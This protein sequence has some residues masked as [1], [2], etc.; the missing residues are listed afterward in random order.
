[1]LAYGANFEIRSSF[2]FRSALCETSYF[3]RV[4]GI[5]RTLLI[6][7]RKFYFY[8]PSSFQKMG[9]N[10]DFCTWRLVSR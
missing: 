7:G 3:Y 6:L 8:A 10:I 1:M 9:W 4:T 2:L 5:V